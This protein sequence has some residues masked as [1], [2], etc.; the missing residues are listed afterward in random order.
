MRL[1]LLPEPA[2]RRTMRGCGSRLTIGLSALVMISLFAGCAGAQWSDP[3]DVNKLVTEVHSPVFQPGE[4]ATFS[5]VFTNPFGYDITNATLV[6]EPYLLVEGDGKGHWQ[7]VV[8]P[9]VLSNST[10]KSNNITIDQLSTGQNLTAA[11]TISS[12]SSTTHGGV[13]SQ[14]VYFIRLSIEFSIAG[15]NTSY[16]S[17]GFFSDEQWQ[18]LTH[19]SIGD[20]MGGINGT[21]LTEL[22]YDGIIPDA[23]FIIREEIPIWPPVLILVIAAFAGTVGIFY[24]L[25][26]D[27]SAY[28]KVFLFL[29]RI[30]TMLQR[31]MNHIKSLV[32]RK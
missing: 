23:S 4:S 25:K 28:P 9:P 12:K 30:Q 5:F 6:A 13:F 24:H 11:W 14:S 16:V 20:S 29:M 22:G 21:Y 31:I 3:I 8:D 26:R 27:P 7:G 18:R 19:P 15:D 1:R 17:R 10:S 32:R 2:S